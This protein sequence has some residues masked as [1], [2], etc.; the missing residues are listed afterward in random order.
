MC[1]IPYIIYNFFLCVT[2]SESEGVLMT[3]EEKYRARRNKNNIASKRS[4]ETRTNKFLNMVRQ[5]D[6]LEVQNDLLRQKIV[7]LEIATKGM[8]AFLIKAFAA[9]RV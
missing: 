9:R 8:K 6:E 3:K 7:E 5:C 1:D 4:R 2:D